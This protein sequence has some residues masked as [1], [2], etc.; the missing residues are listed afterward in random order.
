[1]P[2]WRPCGEGIYDPCAWVDEDGTAL[3]YLLLW[4]RRDARFSHRLPL[5]PAGAATAA[6]GQGFSRRPSPITPPPPCFWGSRR[7]PPAIRGRRDDLRRLKFYERNG[8]RTLGYDTPS[9]ASIS[10]PSAGAGSP[11]PTR[12][13]SSRSTGR[14]TWTTLGRSGS[15]LSPDPPAPRGK[16]FPVTDWLGLRGL[17]A[18]ACPPGAGGIHRRKSNRV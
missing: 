5:R 9:S 12:A 8:A 6:S 14:S 7:P 11:C 2:P 4:K 3:G 13:S 10:R 1:M 18:A 17:P 16:P 15:P